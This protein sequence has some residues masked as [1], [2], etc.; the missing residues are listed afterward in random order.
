M[1]SKIENEQKHYNSP[2]VLFRS[3]ESLITLVGIT[4]V[5]Y[6]T[7]AKARSIYTMVPFATEPRLKLSDTAIRI[8]LTFKGSCRVK[9]IQV[10]HQQNHYP[11]F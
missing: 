8:L 6:T 5:H 11:I 3:L 7:G 4:F 10:W 2:L 9:N 1:S